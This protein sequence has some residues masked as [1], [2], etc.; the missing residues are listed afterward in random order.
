MICSLPLKA[1]INSFPSAK[2]EDWL[3]D[4]GHSYSLPNLGQLK[5]TAWILMG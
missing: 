1:E 2:I 3:E 4:K 5:T